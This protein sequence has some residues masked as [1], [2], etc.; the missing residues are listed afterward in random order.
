[1]RITSLEIDHLYGQYCGKIEFDAKVNIL[2]GINGSFKSTILQLLHDLTMQR[3][4]SLELDKAV[5]NYAD[6]LRVYFYAK[7]QADNGQ[8][9]SVVQQLTRFKNNEYLTKDAFAE[10]ARLTLVKTFDNSDERAKVAEGSTLDGYLETL[11]VRYTHYLEDLAIEREEILK[12]EGM[13]TLEQVK[14]IESDKR[15]FLSIIDSFFQPSQKQLDPK[16]SDLSFVTD[17]GQ[18]IPMHRLSSGE[19]QLLIL[20]L[21]VFLQRQQPCVVLMDEPEL[22]LHINGQYRLLNA[23]TALNPNA[24]FIL[25]THSPSIFGDG[26]GDKVIYVEDHITKA[27]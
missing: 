19:K 12:S 2:A 20:L 17:E 16:R 8:G 21:E 15:A 23:L 27:E 24:Q 3:Q 5:V 4:P 11:L 1:M 13:I 6:A 14:K 9:D 10:F 25:T 22:S 26:W 18:R 7:K